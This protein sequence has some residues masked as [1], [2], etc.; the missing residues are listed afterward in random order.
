MTIE[1]WKS[2]YH[3]LVESP[4]LCLEEE[5]NLVWILKPSNIRLKCNLTERGQ[6]L[7]GEAHGETLR[8]LEFH[9]LK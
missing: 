8:F 7:P 2:S 5:L 6:W 3:Q 4:V 1:L 9:S